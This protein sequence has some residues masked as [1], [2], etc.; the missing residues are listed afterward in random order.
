MDKDGMIQAE[1]KPLP[2]EFTDNMGFATMDEAGV[3]CLHNDKKSY[4]C[5]NDTDNAKALIN[6]F[7][8]VWARTAQSA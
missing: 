8:T 4:F 6:A 1:E 2:E 5:A 3:R 7:T